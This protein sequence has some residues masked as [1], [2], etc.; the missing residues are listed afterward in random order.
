MAAHRSGE[1]PE[2]LSWGPAC[3]AGI[4]SRIPAATKGLRVLACVDGSTVA[5]RALQDVLLF[6]H[7]DR[8][9]ALL[10]L[11]VSEA[12]HV[13]SSR[14]HTP[15]HLLVHYE[16]S[17]LAR[18]G[19][20]YELVHLVMARGHTDIPAAINAVAKAKSVDMIVM[21]SYGLSRHDRTEELGSVARQV[22]ETCTALALV[23]KHTAPRT[24][25]EP[26]SILACIDG[27][28][29]SLDALANALDFARPGD[30]VIAMTMPS[31]RET[32]DSI[33]ATLAPARELAAKFPAVDCEIAVNTDAAGDAP[34]KRICDFCDAREID[35][36]AV[37]ST[38]L[39]ASL[40][41]GP[42]TTLLGSVGKWV[43]LKANCSVLVVKAD[44]R[45][46]SA[47]ATATVVHAAL[48]WRKKA[49]LEAH[50]EEL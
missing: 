16:T 15:E 40:A 50:P 35:F 4:G 30:K 14:A 11:H 41:S 47:G 26:V 37:G 24:T 31:A 10:V 9:D 25:T 22:S 7:A 33:E 1:L 32:R 42:V 13:P 34:G 49:H 28:A 36:V 3:A 44:H 48:R 19:V 18:S 20:P 8:H 12:G 17:L 2:G 29:L 27:S 21:G 45:L 38:G 23:V 39:A 5:E 43:L 6:L 46:R